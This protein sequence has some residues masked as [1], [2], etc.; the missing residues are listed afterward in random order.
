M[1]LGRI[2][3]LLKRKLV[4]RIVQRCGKQVWNDDHYGLM[5]RL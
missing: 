5:D 2:I 4:W 3:V 1:D